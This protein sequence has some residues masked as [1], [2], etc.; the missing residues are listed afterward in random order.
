MGATQPNRKKQDLNQEDEIREYS[1]KTPYYIYDEI[2][3]PNKKFKDSKLKQ[4]TLFPM[5]LLSL[6]FTLVV[7]PRNLFK[8]GS[9]CRLWYNLTTEARFPYLFMGQKSMAFP[10]S[11]SKLLNRGYNFSSERKNR[12]ELKIIILGAGGVGKS[13]TTVC[14][15][16]N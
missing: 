13:A 5:E 10:T 2:P 9:V 15:P 7:D 16:I 8:L 3:T 14:S 6:I 4:S 11:Y 12:E 1:I